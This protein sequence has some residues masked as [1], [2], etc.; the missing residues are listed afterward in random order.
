MGLADWAARRPLSGMDLARKLRMFEGRLA[1]AN[2]GA[3]RSVLQRNLQRN[4]QRALQRK[5]RGQSK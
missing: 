3:S 4:L 1:L 2:C 5:S